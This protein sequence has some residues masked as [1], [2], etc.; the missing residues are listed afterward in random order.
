MINFNEAILNMGNE[1]KKVKTELVEVRN[2]NDNFA[3]IQMQLAQGM[4]NTQNVLSLLMPKIEG[5]IQNKEEFVTATKEIETNVIK[6]VDGRIQNTVKTEMNK[7]GLNGREVNKLTK[8]RQKKII[9]ICGSTKSDFYTLFVRFYQ[10]AMSKAYKEKFDCCTYGDVDA[11]RF[12][13]AIDFFENFTVDS[14]YHDWC[15]KILHK[16]YNAGE[17]E[18]QKKLNAYKRYFGVQEVG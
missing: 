5:S 17:I 10:S 1:I 2:K 15:V 18:N 8:C 11:D 6:T 13:E 16:D 12:E 14:N 4:Q 3:E 7:R 9:Q